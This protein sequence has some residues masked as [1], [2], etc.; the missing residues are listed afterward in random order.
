MRD[1]F[2]IAIFLVLP[3]TYWPVFQGERWVLLSFALPVIWLFTPLRPVLSCCGWPQRHGKAHVYLLLFLCWAALTALWAISPYEAAYRMWHF[4]VLAV[5]FWVGAAL[6]RKTYRYCIFAV[7]LAIAING[8][9]ALWQANNFYLLQFEP[10]YWPQTNTTDYAPNWIRPRGMFNAPNHLAWAAAMAL[11]GMM[12][13]RKKFAELG[14]W[15]MLFILPAV[16]V[17]MSKAAFIALA[18]VGISHARSPW[19]YMLMVL[20]IPVVVAWGLYTGLDTR[21]ALYA[22]S[23]SMVTIQ[24]KGVGSFWAEYPA[25]K[26]AVIESPSALIDYKMKPR[27]AHNDALTVAIEVGIIGLLLA[28]GFIV[29]AMNARSRSDEDRA[30]KAI[31]WVFLAVGLFSF[32]L[33]T[34]TT[35]ALAALSAGFLVRASDDDSSAS[36]RRRS[37][38]P[39]GGDTIRNRLS[40][41][42]WGPI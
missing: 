9:M 2:L 24:G 3:L 29:H 1:N 18:I 15:V 38:V 23:L 20:C 36:T 39:P 5:V 27:T 31:V 12:C 33:F 17:P 4:I 19:K 37:V 25:Y 34:P 30:A 22:N 42:S 6:E 21:V 40:P 26:D 28:L 35:A 7:S 11:V 41:E 8:V 10:I 13:L 16:L 14:R 32:P